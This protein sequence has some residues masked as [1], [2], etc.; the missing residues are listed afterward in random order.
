MFR[1]LPGGPVFE[2]VPEPGPIAP[3]PA[4]DPFPG[5]TEPEPQ[6]EQFQISPDEWQQQ[7]DAT[8]YIMEQLQQLAQLAQPQDQNAIQLPEDSLLTPQDLEVIGQ[9]I[10]HAV[11]P[12]Q[13]TQEQFL[14]SEGE[15]RAQDVIADDISRN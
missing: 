10:S 7:R 15:E 13:Q 9:L 4:P 14:Q 6:A 3:P 1:I 8:G 5:Q 11:A 2:A 12:F